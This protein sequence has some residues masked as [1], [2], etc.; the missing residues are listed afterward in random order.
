[1][2]EHASQ[3]FIDIIR[4]FALDIGLPSVDVEKLVATHR[5]NF[6]ALTQTAQLT[7]EGLKSVAAK[8]KETIEAAFGEALAM[9]RSVSLGGDP[10][11]YVAKHAEAVNRAFDTAL[12]N[13]RSIAEHI[14][15][16]NADSFKIVANRI[17]ESI[18][19]FRQSFQPGAKG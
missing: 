10:K 3:S 8:Q 18:A 12:G 13:T 15:K 11:Q 6:E 19:E 14:Q 1:M 7:T 4:Q 2:T 17:T 16:T 9:A 5:K